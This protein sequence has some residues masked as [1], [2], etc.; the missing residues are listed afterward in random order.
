MIVSK[1]ESFI[2]REPKKKRVS[3]E[4]KLWYELD[5]LSNNKSQHK[6]LKTS[7]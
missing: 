5:K 7:Y 2:T 4:K 6:F 3:N 1:V